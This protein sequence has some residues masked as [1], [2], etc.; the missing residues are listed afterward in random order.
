MSERL[1]GELLDIKL[2]GPQFPDELDEQTLRTYQ[3]YDLCALFYTL[4]SY[5]K[6]KVLY[7]DSDLIVT[8]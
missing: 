8:G 5:M 6:D 3:P 1:G 2:I 7:L 4:I